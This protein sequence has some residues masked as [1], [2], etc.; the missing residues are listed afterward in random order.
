M[1]ITNTIQV[2]TI[3]TTAT[4]APME[5]VSL[6]SKFEDDF[7]KFM[8][9]HPDVYIGSVTSFTDN[10]RCR[11]VAIVPT[12]DQKAIEDSMEMMCILDAYHAT[13]DLS[14]DR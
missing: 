7:K 1:E 6:V 11:Y 5:S 14:N 13:S 12:H 10:N 3:T 8:Q 9:N 2:T 4:F